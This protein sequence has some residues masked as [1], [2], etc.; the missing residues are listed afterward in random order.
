MSGVRHQLLLLPARRLQCFEHGVEAAGE[1]A[2]LIIPGDVD[3]A[4]QFLGP[5]DVF[6]GAGQPF[7]RP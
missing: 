7:D 1:A 2:Y 6:G 4:G 3:R 5:R